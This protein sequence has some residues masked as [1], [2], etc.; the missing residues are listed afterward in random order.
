MRVTMQGTPPLYKAKWE[1]GTIGNEGAGE[2]S[3]ALET[4]SI[5]AMGDVPCEAM[6]TKSLKLD[7]TA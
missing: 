5:H 1:H 3:A 6:T 2:P 4:F 7:L